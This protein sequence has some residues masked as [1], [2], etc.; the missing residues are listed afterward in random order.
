MKF[1]KGLFVACGLA[2][3]VAMSS[4]TA[5][6]APA[7]NQKLDF[8][9][10]NKTGVTITEIYVSPTKSDDWEEDVLGK[11]VLKNGERVTI[12]FA[13]SEKTCKW[14]LK[15]VDEDDDEA[16][17]KNLDLCTI[18]ELTIMWENKKP[19]AIIK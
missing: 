4:T 18:N 17:W 10:V 14:D 11:D 9:L 15:M 12:E 2:A 8:V 16:V 6:M 1:V 13:R 5:S 7:Q 3:V 19:T